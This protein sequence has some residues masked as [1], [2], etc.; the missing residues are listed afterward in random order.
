[1]RAT[2]SHITAALTAAR[3]SLPMVNE[4]WFCIST[5]GERWP[6]RVSTMPWPIESSPISANGP[7]GIGAAELV[8]HRGEHARDRL[9][10]RRPGRGVGGVGVHHAADLGHVPVDVGVRGGVARTAQCSPSTTLPSRSQTT[11]AP[12]SG[13]RRRRPLGLMTIRSSPGHAGGDVA[14]RPDDQAVA[15]SSA[16]RS[17]T[18]RAD[19]AIVGVTVGH[20]SALAASARS[21]A[22]PR[23]RGAGAAL[24]IARRRCMTSSPPRPK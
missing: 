10:A 13:R 20:R 18:S 7:T 9:A 2:S 3:A 23:R 16:C 22:A 6:L 1:M 21:A 19:R 12:A 11:M 17:Q 5:A 24:R 8:G 15:D 14:G 4:P